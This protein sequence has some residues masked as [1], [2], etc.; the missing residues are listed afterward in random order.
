TMLGNLNR[1]YQEEVDTLVGSLISMLEP[2]IMIVLGGVVGFLV[3]SMYMPMFQ[4]G[5]AI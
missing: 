1:V 3:V 4:M 2:L 5:D